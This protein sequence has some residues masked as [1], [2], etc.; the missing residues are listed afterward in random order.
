M[1]DEEDCFCFKS[2]VRHVLTE[3]AKDYNKENKC[4][5]IMFIWNCLDND[6]YHE[7]T[8]QCL[9][10]TP[11]FFSVTPQTLLKLRCVL[12]PTF[13]RALELYEKKK[14][15][16][17]NVEATPYVN[18]DR[19]ACCFYEVEGQSSEAYTIFPNINFCSCLSFE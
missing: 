15:T 1:S 12:G 10:N 16:C 11:L 3:A 19:A 2:T 14:V 8:F 9:F 6:W 5:L 13:E 4:N 18:K 17:F 7:F